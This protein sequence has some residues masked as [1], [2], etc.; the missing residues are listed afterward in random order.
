MKY[1]IKIKSSTLKEI[2]FTIYA[3]DPWT[4]LQKITSARNG[5]MGAALKLSDKIEI[6]VVK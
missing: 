6:E 5:D 1:L 3:K 4:A 2:N